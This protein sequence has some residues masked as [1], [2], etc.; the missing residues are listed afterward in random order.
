[1]TPTTKTARQIK[2]LRYIA[3]GIKGGIN[4]SLL[5]NLKAIDANDIN[6]A[7]DSI[8]K[9]EQYLDDATEGMIEAGLAAA[10]AQ[11]AVEKATAAY[12]ALLAEYNKLLTEY[13]MTDAELQSVLDH[14]AEQEERLAQLQTDIEEAQVIVEELFDV[15]E[16]SDDE[17]EL[18]HDDL[19]ELQ[20]DY[21]KL[22]DELDAELAREPEIIFVFV[23]EGGFDPETAQRLAQEAL[24]A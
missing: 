5:P 2:S 12:D 7:A 8:E 19:D 4:Y 24:V 11:G 6:A 1:M 18:L 13:E 10:Q 3:Q 17:V 9:T 22:Q 21:D 23:N 20:A 16:A 14:H 15:I